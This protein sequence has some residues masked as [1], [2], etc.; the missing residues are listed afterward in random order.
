MIGRS[1]VTNN[2]DVLLGSRTA[3]GRITSQNI[4]SVSNTIDDN[5]FDP[6]I[7][8]RYR[9]NDDVSLYA[10]YATSFKSG[11]FDMAVSNVPAFDDDFI[12]GR[13]TTKPGN[14]VAVLP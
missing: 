13:K 1:Q 9:P 2:P 8:L 14:W 3:E 11:A 10:K 12:F 6:Q 4:A 5:S 7:V